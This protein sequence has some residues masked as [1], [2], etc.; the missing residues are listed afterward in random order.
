MKSELDRAKINMAGED[1][2]NDVQK[3]YESLE[4][5]KNLIDGSKSYFD[6]E[7]G[8]ALRTRFNASAEKFG[9]F[10]TSLNQYGEFLKKFSGNVQQFEEAVK[11][12][13]NEIP[14]L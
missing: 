6:S 4:R 3:M 5:V 10:K 8:E 11:E 13:V 9:E 1:F 7:A 2:I 12:T 14:K